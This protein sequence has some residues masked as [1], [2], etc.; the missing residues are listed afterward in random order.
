M[1]RKFAHQKSD[2]DASI[3]I[4]KNVVHV[5]DTELVDTSD[6]EMKPSIID[7]AITI[8]NANSNVCPKK[9][10]EDQLYPLYKHQLPK[11]IKRFFKGSFDTSPYGIQRLFNE[12]FLVENP[13]RENRNLGIWFGYGSFA[14][15]YYIGEFSAVYEKMILNHKSGYSKIGSKLAHGMHVVVPTDQTGDLNP[16]KYPMRSLVHQ[17]CTFK[18]ELHGFQMVAMLEAFN[19]LGIADETMQHAWE[20]FL[21]GEFQNGAKRGI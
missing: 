7:S 10:E 20:T 3:S 15:M 4:P 21:N 11:P 5:M 19:R 9:N 2:S 17:G 6:E 8:S 18:L 14:V 12:K 1:V 16:T 13:P